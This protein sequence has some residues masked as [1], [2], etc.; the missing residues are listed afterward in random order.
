M[1]N[2]ARLGMVGPRQC[3][4]R[5]L[6]LHDP[7]RSPRLYAMVA[8]DEGHTGKADPSGLILKL[9]RLRE[10]RYDDGHHRRSYIAAGHGSLFLVNL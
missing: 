5:A 1:D 9:H 7:R 3:L 2:E 4:R 6:G 8:A 10:T